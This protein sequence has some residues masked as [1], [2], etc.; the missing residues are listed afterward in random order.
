MSADRKIKFFE[1]LDVQTRRNFL[2]LAAMAGVSS[3]VIFSNPVSSL[4]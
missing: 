4:A 1:S 3:S 2:K